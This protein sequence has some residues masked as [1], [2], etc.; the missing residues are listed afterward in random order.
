[1]LRVVCIIPHDPCTSYLAEQ[2]QEMNQLLA[3]Q[4]AEGSLQDSIEQPLSNE[5]PG[6]QF[7]FTP[8]W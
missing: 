5:V 1:M 2:K 7:F 6:W 4:G 8:A 3:K